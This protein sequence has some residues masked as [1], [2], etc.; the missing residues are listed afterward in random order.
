MEFKKTPCHVAE[1]TKNG[2][3]DMFMYEF[4]RY[5]FGEHH[6]WGRVEEKMK[7]NHEF[8]F[9]IRNSKLLL[10]D[11]VWIAHWLDEDANRMMEL[12]DYELPLMN[13]R[14]RAGLNGYS[15]PNQ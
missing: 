10:D 1:N 6:N 4:C 8:D 14:M 11:V 15:N 5:K 12:Q 9:R 3:S 2:W 13:R 7:I